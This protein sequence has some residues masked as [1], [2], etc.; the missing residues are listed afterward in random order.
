MGTPLRIGIDAAWACGARTGTGNYTLDL[1]RSL[2]A[3]ES[4]HEF[5]L[6]FRE[7]CRAGNPLYGVES[8]RV[9]RRVVA[10]SSTLFRS[11]FQLGRVAKE[12]ELDVFLSPAYFL[13]MFTNTRRVVA[14]FD[15]NIYTLPREWLRRGRVLDFLAMRLLLPWSV[16]V[17]DHIVAIS[18]STRHDL[19]RLF[20]GAAS[21]CTVIYPGLGPEWLSRDGVVPA[22]TDPSPAGG[23]FLYVGVMAP[24]KNVERLLRAFAFFK[25]RDRSGFALVLAGRECGRYMAGTLRPLIRALGLE[26]SVHWNGFVSDDGLKAL[27]GRATAV[28]YPSLREGFGYPILEAMAK[29]V[30]VITS[31]VSSCPEVAGDAALC[32]DPLSVEAIGEAMVRVAGDPRLRAELSSRGKTRCRLFS[33]DAMARQYLELMVHLRPS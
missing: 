26:T 6:Y 12:E 28:V 30:P 10:S 32:V 20:P 31:S 3:Q 17:A 1:V 9:T 25:Q 33:L 15:L 8:P 14:F 23:F 16:K 4:A 2:L 24:S 7:C 29:G 19:N 18:E 5:H 11:V 22:K 21:K 13:P 27:Y